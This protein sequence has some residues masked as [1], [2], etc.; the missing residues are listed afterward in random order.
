MWNP[1]LVPLSALSPA[2]VDWVKSEGDLPKDLSVGR[3]ECFFFPML[4]LSVAPR[5]GP[6]KSMARGVGF[7]YEWLCL[8]TVAIQTGVLAA[9]CADHPDADGKEP[10]P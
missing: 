8:R 10:T 2:A 6:P 5:G 3:I 1:Q 9:R 7:A 4:K